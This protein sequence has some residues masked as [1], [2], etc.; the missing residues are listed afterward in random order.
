MTTPSTDRL[1]LGPRITR[2]RSHAGDRPVQ[3]ELARVAKPGVSVS[4][5]GF[6]RTG[7]AEDGL[8]NWLRRR[9]ALQAVPITQLASAVERA[10]FEQVE[11]RMA[12]ARFGYASARRPRAGA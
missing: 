12:G 1:R 4:A 11:T 8:R 9:F 10:G 2:T 6:A 3:P 5:S 7:A